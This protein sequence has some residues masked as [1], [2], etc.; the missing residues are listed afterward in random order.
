MYGVLYYCCHVRIVCRQS[1]R[2]YAVNIDSV[3][4][5]DMAE[6]VQKLNLDDLNDVNGGLGM[7][8]CTFDKSSTNRKAGKGTTLSDSKSDKDVKFFDLKNNGPVKC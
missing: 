3:K 4:E 1:M 7:V 6:N 8:R 5:N 2:V